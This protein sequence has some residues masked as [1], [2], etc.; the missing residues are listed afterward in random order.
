MAKHS[1]DHPLVSGPGVILKSSPAIRV[2]A[3]NINPSIIQ[4]PFHSCYGGAAAPRSGYP[5]GEV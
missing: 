2:V 5:Y 4:V 3:N 1:K